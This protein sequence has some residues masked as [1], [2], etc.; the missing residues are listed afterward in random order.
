[1]LPKPSGLT[2]AGL[3]I[4]ALALVCGIR[5]AGQDIGAIEIQDYYAMPVTGRIDG[6]GGGPGVL[7]SRVNSLR[8]EPGGGS[9]WFVVDQNGPVYILDK[10]TKKLSTYLDF[11][12]REGHS[13]LFAKFFFENGFG[14]GLN[15]F[16]FDPDYR[17][18]GRFY[19]VHAESP[20]LAGSSVPDA[21]AAPG[22]KAGAYEPTLAVSTPG[23]VR[24]EGVLVEWTDSNPSNATFEGTARELLRVQLNTTSHPLG[25]MI[26]N[27][28]A[29]PGDA[30][31]RVMYLE[32]G[33]S[34]SGESTDLSMRSN[35]QRLDNLVG[36]ILRVIP[37]LTEHATTS[38]V[39]ENGRY[40]I[41][42]DNPFV[43]TKGARR[44]IWAYG[45]RNPHRLSWAVDP[46][47]PSS[48]RLIANSVGLHTWEAVYVIRRGANYGYS[49]REGNQLLKVD[50][51]LAPLPTVDRIP[52]QIGAAPATDTVTPLYP[53]LHYSHDAG[54][55][56]DAIGS[57]YVYNGRAIPALRGKYIVTDITTG[58]IWW[59][60]YKAMLAADDGRPETM[61]ELHPLKIAWTSPTAG[62][63]SQ[64]YD[65]MFPI[66]E[67]TYHARGGLA[68]RLPGAPTPAAPD[69]RADV[70]LAAD[71]AGE[72]YLYSKTDGMIRAVTGV[73]ASR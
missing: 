22:L 59:A 49:L 73:K 2:F 11:N 40:R 16:Q 34:A 50:N 9:R 36:K 8:D 7:L 25:E 56:G 51:S 33:D 31:W 5:V 37:D 70:R 69:G 66:V 28:V 72:L 32:C 61:A 57:G 68:P 13:G 53:V 18:N 64:I 23:P 38:T 17:R 4:S 6:T 10:T 12:G 47:E 63:A 1:V 43:G 62:A 42:N 48:N 24:L 71:A 44:E 58:R 19:T 41:P 3:V 26:F 55:G 21:K 14:T 20:S 29:R 54:G 65:T 45:L 46:A 39:S 67:M 52:V 15:A 60:D 27:P 30:D 35:P